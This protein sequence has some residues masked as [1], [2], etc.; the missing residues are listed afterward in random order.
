[1]SSP[2]LKGLE[3]TGLPQIPREGPLHAGER[4]EK[5]GRR[6]ERKETNGTDEKKTPPLK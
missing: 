1:M 5:K 2:P 3:L 6:K 4:G